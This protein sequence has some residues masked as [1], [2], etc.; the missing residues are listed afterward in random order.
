MSDKVPPNEAPKKE[1]SKFRKAWNGTKDDWH[2]STKLLK[3]NAK[4]FIGTE[5]FAAV[6]FFMSLG[7]ILLTLY[8]LTFFS[9]DFS[10]SGFQNRFRFFNG[11]RLIITILIV[12]IVGAYMNCQNG[13]AWEIMSSG[14][15]FTQVKSSFTYFKKYWWQYAIISI[16][17]FI[18]QFREPFAISMFGP[19]PIHV[20]PPTS[21][22][23]LGA[24]IFMGPSVTF[25]LLT[26]ILG[27]ILEFFWL[28][29]IV[30][31][32]PSITAQS[33]FRNAFR[34][35]RRMMKANFLRLF[36][37]WGKIGR[38]HV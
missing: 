37:T 15:M 14:D 21:D 25:E 38:A 5:L 24:G 33:N 13:L 9:S 17:L 6:A 20:P 8:F 22:Q 29:F 7:I 12:I 31:T 35:S 27:F 4:A 16:L 28:I 19:E 30:Q 1:P 34:E 2:Q 23:N 26:S 10:L 18:F 11:S 32:L 36:T 3:Q